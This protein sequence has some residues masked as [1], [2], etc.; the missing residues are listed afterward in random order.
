MKSRVLK[1]GGFWYGQV[2]GKHIFLGEGWHTVTLACFTRVG[3]TIALKHWL[4][5]NAIY[6]IT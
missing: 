5:H 3:A 4:N 2:Y 1:L 6:E